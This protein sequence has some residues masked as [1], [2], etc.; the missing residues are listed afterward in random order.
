MLHI[1]GQGEELRDD[2]TNKR[3]NCVGQKGTI[4]SRPSQIVKQRAH[5]IQP[6]LSKIWKQRQ[7]VQQLPRKVSLISE[8]RTILQQ[9]NCRNSRSKVEWKKNS[10]KKIRNLG[11]PCEVVLFFGNF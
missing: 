5:S 1:S 6:N 4:A 10:V 11:I 2:S 3:A 7:I 9:N 8:M